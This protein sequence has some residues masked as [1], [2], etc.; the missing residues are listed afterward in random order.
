MQRWYGDN[1]GEARFYNNISW[2]PKGFDSNANNNKQGPGDPETLVYDHSL[3]FGSRG[4][5]ADSHQINRDPSVSG[6]K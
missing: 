6:H 3:F 2:C 5:M 1:K 4:P